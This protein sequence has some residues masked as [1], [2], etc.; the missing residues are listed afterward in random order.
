MAS[1]KI[2]PDGEKIVALYG[3]GWT[4]KGNP[5]SGARRFDF[6]ADGVGCKEGHNGFQWPYT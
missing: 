3:W 4:A 6:V 1:L 5:K 2:S